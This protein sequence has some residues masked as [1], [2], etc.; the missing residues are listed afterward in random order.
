MKT[1]AD[2][3][4]ML[5]EDFQALRSGNITRSEARTRA[6]LAKQIVDT[7][8]LEMIAAAANTNKFDPV[9]IEVD[10]PSPLTVLAAE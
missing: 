2:L 1:T 3:R 4:R 5:I 6:Y 10:S 7:M 8:K 9:V